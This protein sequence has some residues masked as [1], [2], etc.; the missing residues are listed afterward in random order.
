MQT[1]NETLVVSPEETSNALRAEMRCQTHPVMVITAR[2]A[3]NDEEFIKSDLTS[4]SSWDRGMAVSSLTTVSMGS[5]T[6]VERRQPVLSFNIKVPS[7]TWDAIQARRKFTVHVLQGSILGAFIA[8]AFTKGNAQQAFMDCHSAGVRLLNRNSIYYGPQLLGSAVKS[9]L[10]CDLV[11]SVPVEDHVIVVGTV[12]QMFQSLIPT[13]RGNNVEHT[14]VGTGKRLGLSYHA[15]NYVSQARK[16]NTDPSH[17]SAVSKASEENKVE[18][19]TVDTR[20]SIP[21]PVSRKNKAL[22]S[23]PVRFINPALKQVARMQPNGDATR[24]PQGVQSPLGPSVESGGFARE[25]APAAR[26]LPLTKTEAPSEK[27][28]S[29]QELASLRSGRFKQ[30]GTEQ[31]AQ[32]RTVQYRPTRKEPAQNIIPN[33]LHERDNAGQLGLPNVSSS[34]DIPEH[35]RNIDLE[36][37]LPADA[38]NT[39]S[40]AEML[41]LQEA[42]KAFQEQSESESAYE[43]DDADV[44]PRQTSSG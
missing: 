15:G 21:K 1:P 36:D 25:A 42:S 29:E 27:T 18:R 23:F 32:A 34:Y 39:F 5:G 8:Q 24:R 35:L 2:A 17:L 26:E 43:R 31:P 14:S 16:I 20:Q 12:S 37:H 9:R 13:S 41:R 10:H 44:K 38:R 19:K 28:L 7:S 33:K 30:W 22:P 4:I 3:C 11:Q 40:K 6:G